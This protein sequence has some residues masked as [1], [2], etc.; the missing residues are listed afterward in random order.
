MK[1]DIAAKIS[2]PWGQRVSRGRTDPGVQLAGTE[3]LFNAQIYKQML[4]E[5]VRLHDFESESVAQF[6]L[7]NLAPK[8]EPGMNFHC[9]VPKFMQNLW[10]LFTGAQNVKLC[11]L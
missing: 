3:T 10:C 1:V 4:T 11:V 5:W 7:Q 8:D 6:R 9:F 2:G